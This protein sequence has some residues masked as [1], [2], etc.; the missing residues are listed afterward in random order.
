ML[1][2]RDFARIGEVPMSTLRYYDEIGLLRPIQ[3][4][5]ATGHRFYT[6]DQLPRLHRI[7]AFKELGIELGR[8]I[9]L[10]DEARLKALEQGDGWILE[11][12]CTRWALS[13]PLRLSCASFRRQNAW[14]MLPSGHMS[15]CCIPL[16]LLFL[17]IMLQ[18]LNFANALLITLPAV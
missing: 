10:L 2:I 11:L 7:L 16:A 9:Q 4:D 17:S 5:H 18:P 8:I 3:V 15:A 1:G 13:L 12:H 6:I 14:G